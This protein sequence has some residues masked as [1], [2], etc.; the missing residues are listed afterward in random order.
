MCETDER[1]R[2]GG[3]RHTVKNERQKE[4]RKGKKQREREGGRE[5]KMLGTYYASK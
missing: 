5:K 1:E 3:K 4:N 2:R